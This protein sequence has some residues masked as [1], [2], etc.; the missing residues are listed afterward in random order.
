MSIEQST[1]LKCILSDLEIHQIGSDNAASKLGKT[2]NLSVNVRLDDEVNHE[3]VKLLLSLGLT[4]KTRFLIKDM[5]SGQ[6]SYL[7]EVLLTTIADSLTYTPR[8]LVQDS[9]MDSQSSNLVLSAIVR[10]GNSPFCI[11]SILRG[12]IEQPLMLTVDVENSQRLD[13]LAQQDT[14]PKQESEPVVP[15]AR[16][17][18]R[19]TLAAQ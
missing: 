13:E 4:I 14:Q 16:S 1:A 10:V 18:R 11:P 6:E 12:T 17:S 8:L 2:F 7:G 5:K 15:K 3:L 19:K 9:V